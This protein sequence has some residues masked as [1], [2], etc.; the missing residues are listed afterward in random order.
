MFSSYG[1]MNSQDDFTNYKML[2][3]LYVYVVTMAEECGQDITVV[4]SYRYSQ[5]GPDFQISLMQIWESSW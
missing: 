4:R 2:R 5:H 1:E 3:S